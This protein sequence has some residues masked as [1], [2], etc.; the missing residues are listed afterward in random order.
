M[1]RVPVPKGFEMD[2]RDHDAGVALLAD[3]A[4]YLTRHASSVHLFGRLWA[5][6]MVQAALLEAEQ[7]R[8]R[9]RVDRSG[10]PRLR[11]QSQQLQGMAHARKVAAAVAADGA[12]TR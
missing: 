8:R 11:E 12:A 6:P 7:A 1:L 2:A 4:P 10:D 9:M 5:H 3:I